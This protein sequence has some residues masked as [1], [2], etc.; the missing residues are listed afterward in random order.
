MNFAFI[1]VETKLDCYE[2]ELRILQEQLRAEQIMKKKMV[3]EID[4]LNRYKRENR[5]GVDVG[6]HISYLQ[7]VSGTITLMA[8]TCNV[9]SIDNL[10]EVTVVAED[11]FTIAGDRPQVFHWEKY[12]FKMNVP[13]GSLE[14]DETCDVAFKAIAHG[15]LEFPE[16]AQLVSGVYAIC[17]PRK[18]LQPV[19]VELEHCVDLKSTEQCNRLTFARAQRGLPYTFKSI[20][21]GRFSPKSRVGKISLSRFSLVAIIQDLSVPA[22]INE[23]VSPDANHMYLAHLLQYHISQQPHEW[24]MAFIATKSL[25]LLVQVY[26]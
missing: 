16:K 24:F 13:Q 23:E 1:F 8:C 22:S 10:C 12:G 7:P 26:I 15:Q 3:Q 19:T 25:K 18:L 2:N 6:V 21:G 17:M 14:A 4:Y 9:L 11:L 5:Y 20:S